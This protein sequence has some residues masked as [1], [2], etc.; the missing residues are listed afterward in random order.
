M[1]D[2]TK[3]ELSEEINKILGTTI[4]LEKLTKDDLVALH[5]ALAKFKEEAAEFPFPLLD[6]PIG[7]ILDKKFM[8]RPLRE[9]T[10][11]D[12]F[13][14]PKERKGLL[15]LGLFPRLLRRVEESG[16]P[17]QGESTKV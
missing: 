16:K 3:E 11:S 10:L 7:E 15:G 8:N 12:L 9:L 5:D 13:G 6:R 4:A 2:K 14:L 1:P 17:S